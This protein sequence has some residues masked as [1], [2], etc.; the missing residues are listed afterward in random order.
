MPLFLLRHTGEHFAS[1]EIT[2]RHILDVGLFFKRYH[3][4]IDWNFVSHVYEDERMQTF[5]NGIATICVEYVGIAPEC[6]VSDGRHHTYVKDLPLAERI[7]SDVFA[8][9]EHLPMSTTGIHTAWQKMSYVIGKTRRWWRT[10]WKY[11]L[12]YNESL[13]E[14]FLWLAKSRLRSF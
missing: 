8:E 6:F 10:R 5:F 4:D 7:L 12:V 2:L 1:N 11:K 9:K 3:L 13:A 14:S